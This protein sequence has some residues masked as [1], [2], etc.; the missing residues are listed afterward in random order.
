A[1]DTI[2]QFNE[3]FNGH[4]TQDG[5]GFDIDYAQT[6]TIVQYNYSHNNDGGFILICQPSGAVNERG[7]VRYNISQNDGARVFHLS[8]PTTNTRVY[9]NTIYSGQGSTTM[10]IHASSWGGYAKSISF[11]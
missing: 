6:G 7:I 2:I 3:A 10:P 9:N 11:E 4:S 1:D 5:Q 8:G